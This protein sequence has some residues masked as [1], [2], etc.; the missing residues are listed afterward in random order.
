M[1]YRIVS[2]FYTFTA[3]ATSAD[4]EFP[5]TFITS[6]PYHPF[7][8]WKSA[9]LAGTVDI[10]LDAGAGNLWSAVAST[11]ALFLDN[12][13]VTSVLVQGNSV[14]S[15][16]GAPPWTAGLMV[17]TE[18]YTGRKRLAIRLTDLNVNPCSY[19][20]LNIRI[21]SQAPSSGTQYQAGTILVGGALDITDPLYP[22]DRQRIDPVMTVDYPDGGKDILQLGSARTQITLPSLAVGSS[23]L[24]GML[25]IDQL[26]LHQP[27]VLWDATTSGTADAWLV[28]RSEARTW[29]ERFL[30]QYEGTWSLE[31][32][33]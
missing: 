18:L 9:S 8:P 23:E 6:Y 29:T 20:Y 1:P 2:S 21:N 25:Q 31:E 14:P 32:V 11:P 10:I 5:I 22:V 27:F 19:R 4:T 12:T 17:Q 13:N 24:S 16:W 3:S 33:V 26:G 7:R 30:T 28:R 15:S